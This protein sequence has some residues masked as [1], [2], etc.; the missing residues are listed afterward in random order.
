VSVWRRFTSRTALFAA[1]ALA[2]ILA[3]GAFAYSLNQTRILGA[4][5]RAIIARQGA[6]AKAHCLADAAQDNRRR[7]LDLAL[8]AADRGTLVR[9]HSIQAAA[10]EQ[11]DRVLIL[12]GIAY[13]SIALAARL[14]DIPEYTNP[15]S[16]GP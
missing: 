11:E 7:A 6:E 9:L 4:Q 2:L 13:Y 3:A 5:N 12:S 15:A 10:S 14:A 16:C 1:A 8:I